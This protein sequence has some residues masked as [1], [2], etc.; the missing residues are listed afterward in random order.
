MKTRIKPGDVIGLTMPYSEVCMSMRVS[1]RV[2]VVRVMEDMAQL[3]GDN[4]MNF[5]S[6]I[7]H[8]EAGIYRDSEGLYVT[9]WRDA[10]ESGR[11][12]RPGFRFTKA[13]T[14]V[15]D[16]AMHIR[17]AVDKVQSG[18]FLTVAE[19][20][21]LGWRDEIPESRMWTGGPLVAMLHGVID[22]KTTIEG[23]NAGWDAKGRKGAWSGERNDPVACIAG[24]KYRITYKADNHQHRREAVMVY[25]G[26]DDNNYHWSASPVVAGTQDMPKSW[27]IKVEYMGDGVECYLNK[28]IYED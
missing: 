20:Q 24:K 17:R 14:E 11:V 27:V 26:Q 2:L 15:Y 16:I 21:D 1:D 23:V 3:V 10:L 28:V 22:G 5:S 12:A 25:L 4:G 7:T 19:L 18:T 6:P 9:D 8:G 13:G